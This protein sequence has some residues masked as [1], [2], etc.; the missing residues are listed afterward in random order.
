MIEFYKYAWEI[1]TTD[2]KGGNLWFDL[3]DENGDVYNLGKVKPGQ[4]AYVD[5]IIRGVSWDES[6]AVPGVCYWE[7]PYEWEEDYG[8]EIDMPMTILKAGKVNISIVDATYGEELA[9]VPLTITEE[10]A[11]NCWKSYLYVQPLQYGT[12]SLTARALEGD[13]ITLNFAGKEQTEIVPES[14]EVTFVELPLCKTGTEGTITFKRNGQDLSETKTVTVK[15]TKASL[16]I[17]KVTKKTKKMT[18]ALNNAKAGDVI[19]VKAG[20]KKYTKKVTSDADTF[21]YKQK[22]KKQK[23]KAKIKVTVYNQFNQVRCK[24]TVKVK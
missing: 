17:S 16:K 1:I 8:M 18:I 3:A 12:T 10:V 15:D 5:H 6:I 13:T 24:K 11:V 19:K 23:K 4:L 22:I 2:Y 7:K 9:R 20:K 14:G 21:K